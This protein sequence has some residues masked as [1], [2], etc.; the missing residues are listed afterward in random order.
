L[1]SILVTE[2][3]SGK[4]LNKKFVP[5]L[6]P[7]VNNNVRKKDNVIVYDFLAIKEC[8]YLINGDVSNYFRRKANGIPLRWSL[9]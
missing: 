3:R 5:I 2:A 7:T 8:V 6:I 4:L 1:F 9:Q